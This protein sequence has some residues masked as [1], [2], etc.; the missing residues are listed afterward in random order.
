M[1]NRLTFLQTVGLGLGAF[2]VAPFSLN[3]SRPRAS[4][5]DADPRIVRAV[6]G[7]THNVIGDMMTFKLTGKDTDGQ[8]TLIEENNN[9]GV[10]I[11]MHVHANEDEIFRVHAGML[12]VQVG[13][14]KT[15]LNPG[16]MAF[17]PRGVPHTWRV[18]GTEKAKVDLNVFPAGI[19]AMFEELAALPE[20]A[21][22]F[23]RV[24]QICGRY[25][26]Q[27]T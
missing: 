5:A 2:S 9:P 16:D 20:G 17:C 24:A 4:H 26:V 27:F 1:M 19:E 3:P 14:Q 8:F 10:G 15:V 18:V 11:P 23:E 7:P 21:P 6:E 22:D 13:D 25:G 12:E